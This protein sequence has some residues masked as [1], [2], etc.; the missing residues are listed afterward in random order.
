MTQDKI[1]ALEAR[2]LDLRAIMARSD[3]HAAKC[4][5]LGKKFSIQYPEEY[6]EYMKA[7]EE[8]NENEKT[9]VKLYADRDFEQSLDEF[10]EPA[11]QTPEEE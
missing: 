3:A 1:N 7:N 10:R 5:K 4:A 9:L 8:F 11:E 2:Q 6:E